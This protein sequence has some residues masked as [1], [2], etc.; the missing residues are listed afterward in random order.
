MAVEKSGRVRVG[1]GLT[2]NLE[3]YE[4]LRVSV[5]VEGSCS[6]NSTDRA[7]TFNDLLEEARE[8]LQLAV[9]S[10]TETV[11]KFLSEVKETPEVYRLLKRA[12]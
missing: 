10:E 11:L 1:L 8:K 5:D 12:R 2:I 9:L 3:N 4:S 6:E 7:K